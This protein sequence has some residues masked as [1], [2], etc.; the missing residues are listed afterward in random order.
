MFFRKKKTPEKTEAAKKT[1]A[2]AASAADQERQVSLGVIFQV[3]ND[4]WFQRENQWL[5]GAEAGSEEATQSLLQK[6]VSR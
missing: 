4:A 1:H 6:P 2:Q 3:I 5:P